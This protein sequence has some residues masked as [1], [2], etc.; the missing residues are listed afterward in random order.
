MPSYCTRND[1]HRIGLDAQMFRRAPREVEGVVPSTGTITIRSHGFAAGDPL[2][3]AVLSSSTLGAA[4]A[5]VPIGTSVGTPYWALPV[6]GSSDLFQISTTPNGTPVTFSDSG[7]G[8]WGVLIDHGPY[9]DAAIVSASVVFDQYARAHA[10]P[11]AADVVPTLCAY[12]A[13]RVYIG[14]HAP[15][16]PKFAEKA[17]AP[18][19]LRGILNE[20]FTVYLHDQAP[21]LGAVDA[22]PSIAEAGAAP[23]RRH[24]DFDLFRCGPGG[25]EYDVA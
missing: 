6:G 9:L 17:E 22:T 23:A 15:S 10:S 20:L 3:L 14:A 18:S 5:S 8:V 4:A 24:G 25:R 1:V 19:W 7:S 2:S 21:I 16:D 13:A 11:I 12:L